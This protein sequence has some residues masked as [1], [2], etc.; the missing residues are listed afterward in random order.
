MFELNHYDAVQHAQPVALPA[1]ERFN[2][3]RITHR[4]LLYWCEHCV[5]CA[6]PACYQ[7]CD[8]YQPR[9]DGHCRR[10]QYGI[11]LGPAG[12]EITFKKWAKLETTGSVRMFPCA[13]AAR[14]ERWIA[15]AGGILGGSR[16]VQALFTRWHRAAKPAAILPSGFLVEVYN[17][18]NAAILQLIMRS[19]TPSQTPPFLA[20]LT[21]P[22]GY[23][24]HY[25]EAASFRE[26]TEAG[27][28]LIS[29][30]PAPETCPKLIFRTADFVIAPDL[31]SVHKPV[32]CMVWDLDGTLW[33][34]ILA[35]N[36]AVQLRP[37]IPE[38]VQALDQRGILQS[39][40]SKNN[41]ANAWAKLEEFGLSEYFLFPQIHWGP[42]S[43]SIRTIAQSLNL[44][45]DAFAFIDDSS[46]ER[47]EVDAALPEVSTLDGA[48]IAGL[49]QN[50]RFQ[51]NPTKDARNRRRYYIE[52]T[53]RQ[54]ERSKAGS[55]YLR[56]LGSCEIRLDI[57]GYEPADFERVAE[58]LQRTNQLNF[59]G[60]HYTR[61]DVAALVADVRWSKYVLRCSDK[62]GDYGAVG[63]SVVG[64]EQ[65]H[66]AVDDFMLSCRVQSK[67]I[68]QA[69]FAMLRRQMREPAT[70]RV[71]YRATGRNR[72][73]YE[74]LT[75]IGFEDAADG[76]F[77]KATAALDCA[78][79]QSQWRAPRPAVAA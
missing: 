16:P 58:L 69:F 41:H 73:A 59:A 31:G 49:L 17:P 75:A 79:I 24:S 12:A 34:G 55:D 39:I 67:F 57:A 19:I 14:A 22:P 62:Y 46:F 53:V 76:M 78:F 38:I 10:F 4:S 32:K 50:P 47:A 42:K 71:N 21:L 64:W 74:V 63:F 77:L 2:P 27:P 3:A 51:G 56:F 11:Y 7:T 36:G 52:E 1:D 6:A 72:P 48:R 18:E 35:E 61:E 5:E 9:R 33:N 20:R 37:E 8:L 40:A 54:R 65:N 26:I 23:S 28:F 44:G 70:L 15:R 68:E 66:I 43:E 60:R 13:G 45:L 25:F 29:L 30:V